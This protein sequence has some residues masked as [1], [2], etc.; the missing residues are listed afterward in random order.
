[1][2]PDKERKEEDRQKDR[3]D[4]DHTKRRDYS[5]GQDDKKSSVPTHSGGPRRIPDDKK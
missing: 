1:M 5:E 2:S 4:E 3:H